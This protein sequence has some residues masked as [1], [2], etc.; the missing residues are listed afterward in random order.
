MIIALN[1]LIVTVFGRL[2]GNSWA[3]FG[4]FL[5]NQGQ[6]CKQGYRLKPPT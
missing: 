2:L 1:D 4:Q 3:A 5:G 6:L